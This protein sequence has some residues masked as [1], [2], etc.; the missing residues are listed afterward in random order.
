MRVA[1]LFNIMMR[2]Q[3]HFFDAA[4]DCPFHRLRPNVGRSSAGV[5]YSRRPL[6]FLVA[7]FAA[8]ATL[9][10]S[11]KAFAAEP[12]AGA[13]VVVGANAPDC[14]RFAAQQLCHY[15]GKLFGVQTAPG[16]AV[17]FGPEPLFLVGRPDTNSVVRAACAN[18]PF[19]KL[20]PQGIVLRRVDFRGH[21]G[22]LVAGGS[23]PATLWA[24]YELVE[25]WGVRFLLHGDVLPQRRNE[26]H[27]F[28][29]DVVREPRFSV[30]MWRGMGGQAWGHES[31]GIADYRRLIDQLAKLKFN[32]LNLVLWPWQ[33][34]LDLQV[35]KL[36]R[37]QAWLWFG[38]H[39]PITPDMAGRQLFGSAKEFWNPDVPLNASYES[40]AAAGRRLIQKVI[41]H[42]HRRGLE[43]VLTPVLGEFPPEFEPM[44]TGAQPVRQL[45][46]LDVVAG[47]K[48]GINDPGLTT[49]TSAVLQTA[50]NTYPE[51]DA[52]GLIMPEFRQWVDQYERAW[53]TLQAK[54]H[55]GDWS[56]AGIL[57]AAARR[58]W[59]DTPE[60]AVAEVKGDIVNLYFLDR[61]LNTL[62]VLKHTRRPDIK[63]IYTGV[64]EELFP[65]LPRLLGPGSE[66]INQ[67]DY[68]P[69]LVARRAEV[70]NRL[71]CRSN[72]ANVLQQTLVDDNIGV[73]PQL[74]TDAIHHLTA[75]IGKAGWAGFMTRT[76][77]VED[78][79]PLVAYLAKASWADGVTP[80]AVYRDQVRAC[81][82]EG[83]VD[84]MLK[85]FREVETATISL[86]LHNPGFS[87]P[88]PG[89]MMNHWKHGPMPADLVADRECYRR[90]LDAARRAQAKSTAA[91]RPY[92]DYWV[93][94]L[95]FAVGYLDT[96]ELV[97][98][99][100]TA[101]AAG[102]VDETRQ[103]VR[104]AM[105]TA[106]R[107]LEAYARVAR[108]QS[109]RGAIA[110]MN[111]YVV[112][113][114]KAKLDELGK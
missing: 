2:R 34:F 49:L 113:A 30:R 28:Q 31:W 97:H 6:L 89:M 33:P 58:K 66:T 81:C 47:P 107:A 114:L 32:C 78:Q 101:K 92:V 86:S 44:L 54:H 96:V 51:A 68:T 59:D 70:L 110:V 17:P 18:K 69:V 88:V 37:R 48:T 91:G 85:V 83:C 93:G 45:G 108:D 41:A 72:L 61:L 109:D 19:P 106:R 3:K 35:G 1:E 40:M 82:G 8:V 11:G 55:L 4:P 27:L 5:Q 95:A 10:W 23:P 71:G 53:R 15:L 80:D 76:Y 94:R 100:A 90:A 99:A 42:A 105:K 87:F 64:A 46:G 77:L 112:R 16:T 14:E 20:S 24:V 63:F 7:G 56:L 60:R 21:P 103:T 79:D 25:R 52:I 39:Y 38:F 36:K 9:V 98:K 74:A 13:C 22:M 73:V 12:Q 29:I 84:D 75:A 50:V 67:I 62:Q 65:L 57:A 104:L 102:Y 43:C 111:E 26:L